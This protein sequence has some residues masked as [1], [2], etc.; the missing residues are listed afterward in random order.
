MV[1]RQMPE[2]AH[3]ELLAV[4]AHELK[5]PLIIIN[6]LAAGTRGGLFGEIEPA[7]AQQ[8]RRIEQTSSRLMRV[9]DSLLNLEK[10]R[11]GVVPLV[12]QPINVSAIIQAVIDELT[13]LAEEAHQEIVLQ[14]PKLSPIDAEAGLTH[15]IIFNLV[16]NALKYSPP[17]ATITISAHRDQAEVC[18]TV[19]DEAPP[20]SRADRRY[21]FTKFGPL[22][23]RNPVP[24]SNGL[25]LY[26]VSSLTDLLGGT[27]THR[28]HETGNRFYVRLPVTRQLNIFGEP[29]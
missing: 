29:A 18:I 11:S 28:S 19:A 6:N 16:H 20:L 10:T 5:T 12:L 23:Q 13:T 17:R 27:L 2:S 3:S 14:T 15:Q 22:S 4:A 8:L 24:G 26:L 21:I 9:V 7:I 1:T 25:G